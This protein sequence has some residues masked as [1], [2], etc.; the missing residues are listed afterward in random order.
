MTRDINTN[1]TNKPS[2]SL[3]DPNRPRRRITRLLPNNL[4]DNSLLVLIGGQAS[5]SD[6][7]DTERNDST[8]VYSGQVVEAAVPFTGRESTGA[9]A[10]TS[11]RCRVHFSSRSDEEMRRNL[12]AILTEACELVDAALSE[13]DDNDSDVDPAAGN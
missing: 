12:I 3:Q 8:R 9:A 10:S 5:S 7:T 2:D 4:V 6:S 1:I 13:D 11:V